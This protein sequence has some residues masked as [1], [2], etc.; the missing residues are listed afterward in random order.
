MIAVGRSGNIAEKVYRNHEKLARFGSVVP[1][2]HDLMN[3]EVRASA[4][5]SASAFYPWIILLLEFEHLI[6]R[7]FGSFRS[8]RDSQADLTIRKVS[9]ATE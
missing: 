1:R 2:I 8:I 4:G 9:M 5:R 6:G 7:N 3:E